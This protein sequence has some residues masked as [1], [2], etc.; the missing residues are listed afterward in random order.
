M[1]QQGSWTELNRLS[2]QEAMLRQ[3]LMNAMFDDNAVEVRRTR[4]EMRDVE[5]RR[6]NILAYL[7]SGLY[8][9]A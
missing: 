2:F 4:D 8:V 1:D 7:C 6:G 3:R 5:A 9:D